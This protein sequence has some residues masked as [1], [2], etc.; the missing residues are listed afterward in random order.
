MLRDVPELSGDREAMK[1]ASGCTLITNG[2]IVDGTGA[3]PIPDGS[4]VL[5]DGKIAYVGSAEGA[6]EIPPDAR[7]LP[8]LVEAHYHPTY[9]NVSELSDLDI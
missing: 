6:P 2:Q 3:P 1:L 8:G 5:Q 4:V 7:R 9:F